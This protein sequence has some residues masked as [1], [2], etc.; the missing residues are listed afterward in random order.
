MGHVMV[1]DREPMIRRLV[2]RQLQLL[3][4][5]VTTA[6]VASEAAEKLGAEPVDVILLEVDQDG[7]CFAF[8]ERAR[9]AQPAARVVFVSGRHTH[10]S[11]PPEFGQADALLLKPFE[12]GQLER[13]IRRL[14]DAGGGSWEDFAGDPE[15]K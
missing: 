8:L 6:A 7:D 10:D 1:V 3:N 2:E 12:L 13:C 5:R 9:R 14:L 15:K 11:V 4:A